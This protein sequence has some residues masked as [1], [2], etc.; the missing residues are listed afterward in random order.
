MP[1]LVI[2]VIDNPELSPE[3]LMAWREAGVQAATL[4]DSISTIRLMG[5]VLRD[6]LP[7]LPSLSSVEEPH[8]V[9]NSTLFAVVDDQLDIRALVAKTEAI[10]GRLRDPN[11][12]IMFVVPVQEVYGG[13]L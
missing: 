12:G 11:T 7:L 9:R 13:R 10:V 5:D 6:D 3:V 1:R 2:A 4:L 8:P